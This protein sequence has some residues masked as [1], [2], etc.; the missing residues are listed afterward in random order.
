M[1]TLVLTC[2]RS[3][4]KHEEE[5]LAS[6]NCQFGKPPPGGDAIPLEANKASVQQTR[7][8]MGLSPVLVYLQS[9]SKKKG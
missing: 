3:T 9:C 5:L 4:P 8:E 2:S 6:P 1:N 7:A